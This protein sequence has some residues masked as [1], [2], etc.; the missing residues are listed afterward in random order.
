MNPW[1]AVYL[2]A[3]IGIVAYWIAVPVVRWCDRERRWPRGKT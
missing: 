2:A 1:L 3:I